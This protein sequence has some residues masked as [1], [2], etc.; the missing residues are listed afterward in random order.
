MCLPQEK[1]LDIYWLLRV[2]LRTIEHGDRTGPLFAFM[3][4]FYLSVAINSYSALKNYFGPVHSMEELPGDRAIQSGRAQEVAFGVSLGS[5]ILSPCGPAAHLH[6]G[7]REA[8]PAWCQNRRTSSSSSLVL[9]WTHKMGP[10]SQLALR[11]APQHWP[12]GGSCVEHSSLSLQS[13]AR[14]EAML[15]ALEEPRLLTDH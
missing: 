9:G 3:P 10:M 15:G 12:Q 4:E 8:A 13:T 7:R 1:M 2:C 11:F 14:S 5:P 6:V